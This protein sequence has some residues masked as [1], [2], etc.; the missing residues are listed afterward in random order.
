MGANARNSELVREGT[1]DAADASDPIGGLNRA[2]MLMRLPVKSLASLQQCLARKHICLVNYL[3]TGA[4][5]VTF[6]AAG[7]LS[8][9]GDVGSADRIMTGYVQF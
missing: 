6:V 9:K 8:Q 2:R 5:S 1:G 3:R 7:V 4:P